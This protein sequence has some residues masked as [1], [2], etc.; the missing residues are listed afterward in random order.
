MDQQLKDLEGKTATIFRLHEAL[1]VEMRALEL[2]H[3]TLVGTVSNIAL[4]VGIISS[5]GAVLG[6]SAMQYLFWLLKHSSP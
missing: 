1:V 6:G 3:T 5:V 4:R 2:L